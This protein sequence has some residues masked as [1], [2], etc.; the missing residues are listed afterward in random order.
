[1]WGEHNLLYPDIAWF[2]V[3]GGRGEE[4]GYCGQGT[5]LLVKESLGM[6]PVPGNE[7]TIPCT[8]HTYRPNTSCAMGD[9]IHDIEASITSGIVNKQGL[10]DGHPL[11]LD[12]SLKSGSLHP[13]TVLDFSLV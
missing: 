1:M 4:P 11:A 3:P 6:Y 8:F 7:V 13:V 5:E 9:F 12:K 10:V 2:L